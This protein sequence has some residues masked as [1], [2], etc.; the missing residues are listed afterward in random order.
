MA[1]HTA[2]SVSV[3]GEGEGAPI[4]AGEEWGGQTVQPQV[5][6]QE[7]QTGEDTLWS[8][9]GQP[10]LPHL[11]THCCISSTLQI[12]PPATLNPASGAVLQ[13]AWAHI[14]CPPNVYSLVHILLY[15]FIPL[16]T[17]AHHFFLLVHRWHRVGH[18]PCP[19]LVLRAGEAQICKI[20]LCPL[21]LRG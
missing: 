8:Q 6:V 16:Y 2:L 21:E 14:L 10:C 15:T 19:V 12:W 18:V 20:Q 4:S 3:C 1:G 17:S 9:Q 5:Y 7:G 11:C 13:S